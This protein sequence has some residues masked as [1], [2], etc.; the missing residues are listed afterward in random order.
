MPERKFE[1]GQQV[2]YLGLI[3]AI[4]KAYYKRPWESIH[5][6]WYYNLGSDYQQIAETDLSHVTTN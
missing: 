1:D 4:D 2:T 3:F 5:P 6:G